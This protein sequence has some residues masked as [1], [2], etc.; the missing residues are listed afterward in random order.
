MATC[1]PEEIQTSRLRGLHIALHSAA[2]LPFNV[3][4]G[5]A[6]KVAFEMEYSAP[7]D[8]PDADDMTSD[9]CITSQQLRCEERDSKKTMGLLKLAHSNLKELRVKRMLTLQAELT[10]QTLP[11]HD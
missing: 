8:T 11:P 10:N 7:G 3:A 5:I 4:A 1:A 2:Q 9:S 6:D